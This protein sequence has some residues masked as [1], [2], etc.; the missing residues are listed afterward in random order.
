LA[1]IVEEP[2]LPFDIGKEVLAFFEAVIYLAYAVIDNAYRRLY[3]LVLDDE[4]ID[5]ALFA[6][7]IGCLL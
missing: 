3:G 5:C 4:I 2:A 1:G 7:I 6:G